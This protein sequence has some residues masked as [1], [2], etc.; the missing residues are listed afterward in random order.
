MVVAIGVKARE[1]GASVWVSGYE[2]ERDL[3]N[4]SAGR[5]PNDHVDR[6]LVVGAILAVR[7]DDEGDVLDVPVV[8]VPTI[9]EN[10]NPDRNGKPNKAAAGDQD[11][12]EDQPGDLS[13]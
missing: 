2:G 3:L 6:P 4:C 7:R 10:T 13:D 9:C 12:F 5:I 11:P 1:V 8:G